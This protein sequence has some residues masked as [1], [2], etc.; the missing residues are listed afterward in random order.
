M[1][2]TSV[3]FLLRLTVTCVAGM[4]LAG[5]AL[6]QDQGLAQ[7]REFARRSMT[8]DYDWS[9]VAPAQAAMPRLRNL[10]LQRGAGALVLAW[11][12]GR[13]H[14]QD[15]LTLAIARR[16]GAGQGA[17]FGMGEPA[18]ELHVRL[19]PLQQDFMGATFSRDFG[20]AGR[21][22]VSAQAVRQQF[23]TPGFGLIPGGGAP[24]A[25]GMTASAVPQEQAAGRGLRLDYRL[26]LRQ[27]WVWGWTAQ[28]R[29]EMD[30]LE[31]VRGIHAEPGDF[32]LPARLGTRLEWAATPQ[33]GLMLEYERVYYS[34][35]KPFT[36]PALPARLLS[37]MSDGGAPAFAWRD[38]SVWSLEARLFDAG[39]GQWWLRY[40]T[41]QQPLPSEPLY[42][43]AL[44]SEYAQSNFILGYRRELQRWGQFE[45]SASHAGS[46]AFLGAGP[47]FASR[48]YARGALTEFEARWRLA[49]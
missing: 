49:F 8:P 36:S 48:T 9:P 24:N 21:F 34:Q 14:V 20:G 29:L 22:S 23:A 25:I 2:K 42:H 4:S 13:A 44:A 12:G 41:R 5:T 1:N 17:E 28:S 33:L 6:A 7:W 27:G 43:Q 40:S 18:P 19:S 39:Q 31:S 10:A 35:I 46:M 26:P 15:S 38:Q 47:V 45:L 16:S 37:L 3:P 30:T 32:D 11:S